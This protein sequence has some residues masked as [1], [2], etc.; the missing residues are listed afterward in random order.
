MVPVAIGLAA[1]LVGALMTSRLLA[2]MLFGVTGVDATT[3]AG[4]TAA[5]AAAALGAT[6]LAARRATRLEPV[7]ALRAE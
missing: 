1:G 5:L 7:V 2:G 4:A 6:L 3:Y